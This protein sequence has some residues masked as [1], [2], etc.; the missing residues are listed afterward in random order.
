[1]FQQTGFRPAFMRIF[2]IPPEHCTETTATITGQEAKHLRLV[3]RLKPGDTI[4]LFDGQGMQYTAQLTAIGKSEATA[5]ILSSCRIEYRPPFLLLAQGLL[6]GKKMDLVIQKATELGVHHL[7]PFISQHCTVTKTDTNQMERWQRIIHESCKQC[8]R[9]I[10]MSCS[11]PLLFGD[12]LK[13]YASLPQKLLLWEQE[14][15]AALSDQT[16]SAAHESTILVIGPEGGFQEG[17]VQLA[18][19]HG[20]TSTS[21]GP[22]TL[23]AE[24]ASIAAIAISQFLLGNLRP[25]PDSRDF[26]T[27]A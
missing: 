8:G 6:K 22:A 26:R 1:M 16:L 17:E 11:P 20:Y 4:M 7:L 9:A 5:A 21:I 3:L 2:F 14:K 15:H 23:R 24:T 18:A 10:P 25:R 13:K 19:S 27:L 12:L